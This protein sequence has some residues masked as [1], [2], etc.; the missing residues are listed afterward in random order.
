MIQPH[1][2][3]DPVKSENPAPIQNMLLD[4]FRNAAEGLGEYCPIKNEL[5]VYKGNKVFRF[6]Y[7]KGE[8]R[9]AAPDQPEFVIPVSPDATAY[10]LKRG[11][12]LL[13]DSYETHREES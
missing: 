12:S 13:L 1:H 2:G 8:L 3:N 11:M 6:T 4:H 7:G 9:F 5:R 10:E